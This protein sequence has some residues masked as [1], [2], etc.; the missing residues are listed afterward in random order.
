[1]CCEVLSGTFCRYTRILHQGMSQHLCDKSV[2]GGSSKCPFQLKKL[3]ASW[4]WQNLSWN[5]I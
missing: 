4:L 1:M 5:E 2:W 3:M